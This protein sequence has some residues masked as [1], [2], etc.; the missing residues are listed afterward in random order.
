MRGRTRYLK[1]PLP[2][3]GAPQ[4]KPVDWVLL[5]ES[6]QAALFSVDVERENAGRRLVEGEVLLRQLD[7]EV[8]LIRLSAERRKR[9]VAEGA[10]V[11]ADNSADGAQGRD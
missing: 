2:K 11:S 9:E 5:D 8:E 4:D 10:E 6:Q 3:R 1:A 7:V